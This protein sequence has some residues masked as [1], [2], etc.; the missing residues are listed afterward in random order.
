M[1]IQRVAYLM[2]ESDVI[3]L[4]QVA[5]GFPHEIDREICLSTL[6]TDKFVSWDQVGTNYRITMQD[7]SFF[8]SPAPVERDMSSHPLWEPLLG[9][10]VVVR[11]AGIDDSALE[12]R[13]NSFSI[14]CC[15]YERRWG[16]DVL[17][18]SRCLPPA[19]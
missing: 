18:I 7:D 16:A 13:G 6:G 2:Y 5:D 11:E 17:H 19:A 3:H 12:I 10:E 14:F 8:S 15:P 1:I 9:R 4:D